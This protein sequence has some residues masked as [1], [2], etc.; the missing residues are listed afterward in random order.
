MEPAEQNEMLKHLKYLNSGDP[1][2]M[3]LMTNAH[4]EAALRDMCCDQWLR[5]TPC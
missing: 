3:V 2:L 4:V 5:A 1:C